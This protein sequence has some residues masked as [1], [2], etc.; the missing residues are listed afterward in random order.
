MNFETFHIETKFDVTV[1]I[2]TALHDEGIKK[3]IN[4]HHK[5]YG[6]IYAC[7]CVLI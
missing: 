5:I 2:F 6:G 3:I 4:I 1:N 7:R